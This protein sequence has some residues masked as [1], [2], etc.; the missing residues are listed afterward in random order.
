MISRIMSLAL[1]LFLAVSSMFFY[2]GALVIWFATFLYDRRLV[3]LHLYTSFWASVYIWI[4]PAWS[5]KIEGRNKID[6]KKTYIIVS[7]HQSQ[8]DILVAFGLFTHFKWVSKSEIFRLPFIGW[9]MSL[10]QY[11]KLKRGDRESVNAM[12][13]Q[14]ERALRG[15]SPVYFF[16]EGTRSETGVL[17][18]FKPGAFI[19]AKK[20]KL[21]ILPVA[22]TGTREALPKHSL[23]IR[24][25]HDIR[26]R[27]L[28]EVPYEKFAGISV[29]ETSLMI[30]K[31]LAEA[32]HET[33]A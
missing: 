24:G 15:G 22:I 3:I 20:L 9:N 16:P 21:P 13:A 18:P 25:R 26:L 10:N 30:R 14:C 28:D 23:I 11:I 17:K 27:V 29:E 8:L 32:V 4:F 5:V 31:I 2:A 33:G 12:M 6:R 1:I 7:N 19:L